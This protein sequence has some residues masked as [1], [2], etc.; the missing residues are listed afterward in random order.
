MCLRDVIFSALLPREHQEGPGQ[1]GH[2]VCASHQAG[3][4][5]RQDGGPDSGERRRHPRVLRRSGS[6]ERTAHCERGG[7]SARAR[8]MNMERSELWLFA[9]KMENRWKLIATNRRSL[10]KSRITRVPGR[11]RRAENQA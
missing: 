7:V 6:P 2:Q 5:G 1:A 11:N 9:D 3:R 10:T 8:V 4:Q